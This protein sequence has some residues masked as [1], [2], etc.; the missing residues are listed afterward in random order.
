MDN[1][2]QPVI[3]E[4]NGKKYIYFF[5]DLTVEQAEL[6][7]ELGLFKYTQSKTEP[8]TFKHLIKSKGVD[9]LPML[10]S[11]LVKPEGGRFQREKVEEVE[12]FFR[13]LPV[14]ELE[15]MRSVAEDFFSKL[16][17]KPIGLTILGGE[18]KLSGIEMLLPLIQKLSLGSQK[19]ENI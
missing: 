2:D 16:N 17:M 14:H 3:F 5:D 9:W 6:G 12:L 11:Y 7:R 8:E 1:L 4:F 18:R 19:T 13:S 10:L 15:K